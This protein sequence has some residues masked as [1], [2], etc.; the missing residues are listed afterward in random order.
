MHPHE[1]ALGAFCLGPWLF[2]ASP[3]HGPVPK[4]ETVTAPSPRAADKGDALTLVSTGLH[5]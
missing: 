3:L 1:W 5:W 2:A 4:E